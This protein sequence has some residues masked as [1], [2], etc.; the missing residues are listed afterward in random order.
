[1]ADFD[2]HTYCWFH[3]EWASQQPLAVDSVYDWEELPEG[4]AVCYL[5][6]A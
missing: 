4:A 5:C 1:V 6:D 2:P 3:K